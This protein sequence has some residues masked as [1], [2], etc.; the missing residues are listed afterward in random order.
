MKVVPEPQ[1]PSGGVIYVSLLIA[2]SLQTPANTARL[3]QMGSY[4]APCDVPDY[5]SAFAGCHCTY[6][7]RDDPVA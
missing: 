4:S 2:T 5:S 1:G 7:R 6:L 3:M